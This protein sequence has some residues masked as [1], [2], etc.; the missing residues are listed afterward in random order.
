VR[1]SG[2]PDIPYPEDSIDTALLQAVLHN[3]EPHDLPVVIRRLARIAKHLLIKEDTYGPPENWMGSPQPSRP[4]RTYR[5][6]P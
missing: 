3:I 1:L 4:N 5:N 2:S 6:G